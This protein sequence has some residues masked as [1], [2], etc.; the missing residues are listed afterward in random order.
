MIR[1]RSRQRMP[2]RLFR[3]Q[4]RGF[5][6]ATTLS[7]R[8]VQFAS[9]QRQPPA[10]LLADDFAVR[11]NVD[12]ETSRLRVRPL[13][14]SDSEIAPKNDRL[15]IVPGLNLCEGKCNLLP[16]LAHRSRL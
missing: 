1:P 6:I 10:V 2:N 3:I 5:T 15:P 8:A 12:R 13:V 4:F 11:I 7:G 14:V 9:P 16:Q